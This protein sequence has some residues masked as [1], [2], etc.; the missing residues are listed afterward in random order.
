MHS[1]YYTIYCTS[2]NNT[3]TVQVLDRNSVN[4]CYFY[5]FATFVATNSDQLWDI[6]STVHANLGEM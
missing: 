1:T 2:L 3:T 4:T 5:F 6:K